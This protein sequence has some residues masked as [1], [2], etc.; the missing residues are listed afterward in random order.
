MKTVML[1]KTDKTSEKYQEPQEYQKMML[2]K[3]DREANTEKTEKHLSDCGSE[4]QVENYRCTCTPL[5]RTGPRS[6]R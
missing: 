6:S 2:I 5:T 4:D 3:M 1:M